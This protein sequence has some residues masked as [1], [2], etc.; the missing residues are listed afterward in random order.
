MTVFEEELDRTFAQ[1]RK[2]MLEKR[3]LRGTTNITNQ[4][5]MGVVQR[6]GEDKLSR[7]KRG[8][9]TRWLREKLRERNIS[10]N[11][12]D[13]ILPLESVCVESLEDDLIDV[14]NYAIIGIS[15][16]HGTWEE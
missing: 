6:M 11:I 5:M 12:I 15:L 9:E 14:A 7:I 3:S 10:V 2:V 1:M 8:V 16:L 13:E 4:G